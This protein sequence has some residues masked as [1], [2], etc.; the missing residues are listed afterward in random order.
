M[1][2]SKWGNPFKVKHEHERGKAINLFR[3]HL[4][5]SGLIKDIGEV[6]GRILLCHC[7][8]GQACHGDVLVEEGDKF[9]E[10]VEHEVEDEM[11]L[12]SE[13]GL[14]TRIPA[15]RPARRPTLTPAVTMGWRGAGGART[16]EG[17]GGGGRPV[18]T[19]GACARRVGGPQQGAGCPPGLATAS[20]RS[21]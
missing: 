9:L 2:A 16:V 21:S 13:D 12:F 1:P 14:P 10:E 15:L 7:R 20:A 5:T 3:D 6:A 17:L 4:H 8:P 19:G 18:Q 11:Q